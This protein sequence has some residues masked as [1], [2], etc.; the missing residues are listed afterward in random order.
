MFNN[1][2]RRYSNTTVGVEVLDYFSE[3]VGRDFTAHYT[4]KVDVKRKKKQLPVEP[5]RSKRKDGKGIR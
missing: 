5:W 4:I 3:L 1:R 2:N